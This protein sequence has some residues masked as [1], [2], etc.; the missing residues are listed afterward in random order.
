M[1]FTFGKRS[2]NNLDGVD[3]QLVE[4][5]KV[6]LQVSSVDFMVIEGLRSRDRQREL[7]SKGLSKTMNSK[8]LTGRAIDIVPHPVDWNDWSRFVKVYE[9]FIEA[10]KLTGIKFRWGGDWNMNGSYRDEKFLDGPHFE[11]M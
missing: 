7:V 11:L 10:S 3:P 9:A 4:L 8:H 5:A 2:L 1:V 6:A